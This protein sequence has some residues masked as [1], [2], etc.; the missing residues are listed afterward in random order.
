MDILDPNFWLENLDVVFDSL[1][2]AAE[3]SIASG[4]VLT[5][6][7]DGSCRYYYAHKNFTLLE[8]RKLVATKRDLSKIE[9]LQVTRISLNR[10]KANAQLQSGRS[11]S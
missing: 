3:L 8:Q 10:L 2:C 6:V 11:T 4:F 5:N 7:E 9:N 1:N